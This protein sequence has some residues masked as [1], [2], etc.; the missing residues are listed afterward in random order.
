MIFRI[1]IYAPLLFVVAA[2][3]LAAVNVI[4]RFASN[5][6]VLALVSSLGPKAISVP[7][8]RLIELVTTEVGAIPK[9]PSA[10]IPRIPALTTV[11]AARVAVPY[12]LA[13]LVSNTVPPCAAPLIVKAKPPVITPG[14]DRTSAKV[15]VT[16]AAK[17]LAAVKVIPRLLFRVTTLPE[18]WPT[19]PMAC[20]TPP[21][22]VIELAVTLAGTAPKLASD[23]IAKIPA[24]MTVP[25]E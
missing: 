23:E 11:A 24:L 7:P 16:V 4:P 18:V 3:P 22:R 15:D 21:L 5:V 14:T 19:I 12:V 25:P 6:T 2:R 9:L 20:N 10:T 8:P 17:P 13:A 1:S